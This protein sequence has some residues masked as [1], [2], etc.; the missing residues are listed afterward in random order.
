MEGE[1]RRTGNKELGDPKNTPD[2]TSASKGF[3]L[4]VSVK[5][6]GQ[7]C[8][9]QSR[10]ALQRNGAIA[11]RKTLKDPYTSCDHLRSNAFEILQECF[12]PWPWTLI[13]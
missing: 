1:T 8:G 3:S 6:L 10:I 11:T 9:M 12:L 2:P 5:Y 7:H 4:L 13:F